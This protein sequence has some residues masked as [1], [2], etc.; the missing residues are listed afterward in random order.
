M[1]Q[2]RNTD[3][4]QRAYDT[5]FSF[6]NARA[7]STAVASELRLVREA[8]YVAY[9]DPTRRYDN[10][11]FVSSSLAEIELQQALERYGPD[12]PP[13]VV[14]E[15]QAVSMTLSNALFERGYL[16]SFSHQFLSLSLE[17]PTPSYNPSVRVERWG[18]EK[19][20][21]FLDLLTTSGARCEPEVWAQ[22]RHLYCSDQFRCFVAFIDETP[23]AWGTSFIAKEC[24]IL[25]NA[26]TQEAFRAR[27]CQT[28]LL[29][30]RIQDAQ[31]LGVKL[32]LT[33]VLAGSVSADNC[34]KAGFSTDTIRTVWEKR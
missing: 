31:Q 34:F 25:A 10:Q 11:V 21:A 23:C 30:A 12:T 28:A 4:T 14:V 5:Y 32:V 22:K 29:H 18:S 13:E 20:D 24:A 15:P 6:N 19:A 26:F 2:T 16:P 7:L 9:I 27:G 3:V 33:D 8:G 17:Q 1:A